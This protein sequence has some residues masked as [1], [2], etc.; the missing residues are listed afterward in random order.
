MMRE[1]M[2]IALLGGDTRQIFAAKKLT[3]DGFALSVWGLGELKGSGL[4]SLACGD[5]RSAVSGAEILILPLPLS[6]DGVRLNCPLRIPEESVRLSLLLEAFSGKV[7]LGGRIPQALRSLAEARGISCIDYYDSELLQLKNALP[8]A[9]G[10]LFV[11]MGELPV[12]L[13][14]CQTAVVGYGRIGSLLAEKL[15]AMGAKVTVLARR[16]EVLEQAALRHQRGILLQ[17]KDGYRGLDDL[18]QDLRVIFN[19]VPKRI[20]CGELLEKIPAGC[21]FVDLASAPGGIDFADAERK[22]IRAIWATALPGKYSPESAGN[23]I[24]ETLETILEELQY[25]DETS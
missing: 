15:M 12:T 6:A 21:L 23:I 24:A 7:V 13:D 20:F 4:D 19:T 2:R 14:G 10:A 25:D 18:P 1:Q 9:E 22:G 16:R 8:T 17:C 11:A 5:W 3:E